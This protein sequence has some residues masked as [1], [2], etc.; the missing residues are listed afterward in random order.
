MP[1]NHLKSSASVGGFPQKGSL[2]RGEVASPTFYSS[3]NYKWAAS[4]VK[5][6]S[7]IAFAFLNI[8]YVGKAQIL[9][10]LLTSQILNLLK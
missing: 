4:K 10:T 2:W 3:G 9:D 1:S 5:H 7:I 6:V 8:Q